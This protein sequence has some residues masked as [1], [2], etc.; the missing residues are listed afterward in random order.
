M[1]CTRTLTFDKLVGTGLS[2]RSGLEG[3]VEMVDHIDATGSSSSDSSRSAQHAPERLPRQV[4]DSAFDKLAGTGLGE[5]S[6]LEGAV[7]MVDHIDATGSSSSD[8]SRSAQH[9]PERRPRRVRDSAHEGNRGEP[10]GEF[11]QELVGEGTIEVAGEKPPK[12]TRLPH[13][14]SPAASSSAAFSWTHSGNMRERK[15]LLGF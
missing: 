4:R 7:E 12:E 10:V 15:G 8:S 5:R 11:A 1:P 14:E 6:G 3:A 13:R 2:E 9:R